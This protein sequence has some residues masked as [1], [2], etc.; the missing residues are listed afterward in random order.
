LA[1]LA[2]VSFL[3]GEFDWTV[4][5]RPLKV[6]PMETLEIQ[7]KR[8]FARRI[9]LAGVFTAAIA[10]AWVTAE[11][12]RSERQIMALEILCEIEAAEGRKL[13]DALV[14]GAPGKTEAAAFKAWSYW[15]NAH[16]GSVHPLSPRFRVSEPDANGK[17]TLSYDPARG[18]EPRFLNTC[19]GKTLWE[20]RYAFNIL[21]T[22]N[23]ESI[24]DAY[25]ER[26]TFWN[27]PFWAC[28]VL[29]LFSIPW[30][31]YFVLD[32]VREV[33]AAIQGKKG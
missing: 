30:L 18:P 11:A 17:V 28:A 26:T 15:R 20:E 7:R 25:E 24:R 33:S 22:P 27:A 9:L 21:L 23:Q 32:R 31:W 29:M 19:S 14:H 8:R 5:Q 2:A 12:R 13:E 1:D 10:F 3:P 16:P 4:Q 6:A